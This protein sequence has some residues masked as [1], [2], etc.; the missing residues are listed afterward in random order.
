M[1]PT[2]RLSDAP[3]HPV[4]S[5]QSPSGLPLVLSVGSTSPALSSPPCLRPSALLRRSPSLLLVVNFP[6]FTSDKSI[7]VLPAGKNP[8]LNN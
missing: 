7:A 6:E 5:F 1:T 8:N 4:V 2:P 3:V